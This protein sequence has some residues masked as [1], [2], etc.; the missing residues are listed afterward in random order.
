MTNEK[1]NPMPYRAA[2]AAAGAA[3]AAGPDMAAP[4]ITPDDVAR[5]TELLRRYKDGKR[6][7]EAVSARPPARAGRRRGRAD[8]RVAVQRHCLEAR[9]RD[10]QLPG[11]GDPAAQRAG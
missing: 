7:L 9:R 6:A 1:T 10:G 2:D 3:E 4:V 11:G 5:G 8:E